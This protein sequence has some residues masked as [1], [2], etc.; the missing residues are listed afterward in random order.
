MFLFI[1]NLSTIAT[2]KHWTGISIERESDT[3][4]TETEVLGEML[5]YTLSPGRAWILPSYNENGYI[6][7]SHRCE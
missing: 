1:P 5:F 2:V 3:N 7:V 6:S 4:S